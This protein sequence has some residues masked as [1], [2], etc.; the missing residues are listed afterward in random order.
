VSRSGY[1]DWAKVTPSA[2]A[3]RRAQVATYVRGAFA[4]GRGTYGARR[5]HAVLAR[6]D[7]PEVASAHSTRLQ[8]HHPAR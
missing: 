5:V 6:S 1:Y 3:L 8:D 4:A 7:D 2:R